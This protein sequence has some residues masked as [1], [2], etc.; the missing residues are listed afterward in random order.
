M[1]FRQEQFLIVS[2]FRQGNSIIPN[3]LHTLLS[4]NDPLKGAFTIDSA[5]L[6][7]SLTV[8]F[9]TGYDEELFTINTGYYFEW[10][11][12]QQG[13]SAKSPITNCSIV[14]VNYSTI[15]Q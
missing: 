8:F 6:P 2:G 13:A 7:P 14:F 11:W 12:I 4:F 15:K 9:G 10:P 1:A 3:Y 5:M